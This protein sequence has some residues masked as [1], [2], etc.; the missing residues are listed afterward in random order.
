MTKKNFDYT[1]WRRPLVDRIKT[2]ADLDEF[3]RAS[4]KVANFSGDAVE[5]LD[6]SRERSSDVGILKNRVEDLKHSRNCAEHELKEI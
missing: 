6:K 3:V 4:R 2:F 1:E 5:V